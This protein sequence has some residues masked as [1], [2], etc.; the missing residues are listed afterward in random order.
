MSEQESCDQDQTDVALRGHEHR[1]E[2]GSD[3]VEGRKRRY[4]GAFA[5]VHR[6]RTARTGLPYKLFSQ[7]HVL[8]IV[9]AYASD[10]RRCTGNAHLWLGNLQRTS[11]FC[12]ELDGNCTLSG[13]ASRFARRSFASRDR[14]RAAGLR[15]GRRRPRNSFDRR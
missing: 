1:D 15:R 3:A 11:S 13:S 2:D 6:P 8:G 14:V 10:S 9:G 7:Q 5:R 12:R 4:D